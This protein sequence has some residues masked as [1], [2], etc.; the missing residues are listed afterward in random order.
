MVTSD[1]YRE[2]NLILEGE[3]T[4]N[5]VFLTVDYEGDQAELL[6]DG[7]KVAEDY[8]R[9][10][11]WEIGVK[12]WDIVTSGD[13]TSFYFSNCITMAGIPFPA[14]SGAPM[15]SIRSPGT[16]KLLP[17]SSAIGVTSSAAPESRFCA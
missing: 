7:S 14:S 2:Y 12:R 5:D 13:S 10:E 15:L 4:G 6:L 9:G 17:E 11:P 8:Y 3:I 1:L 16:V